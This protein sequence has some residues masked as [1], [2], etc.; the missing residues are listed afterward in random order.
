MS[1]FLGVDG[2]GSKTLAVITDEKGHVLGIGRSEGSNYQSIGIDKATQHIGNAIDCALYDANLI[3]DDITHAVYGLAGADRPKDLAIVLPACRKLPIQSW[4]VVCDTMIGLRSGSPS[5]TGIVLV[6]G[7]GT[8]AAGRNKYGDEVQTGG[9]GYLYGDWA[10]GGDLARAAFRTAIRS[11]EGRE[12]YSLLVKLVPEFLGYT[13]VEHM[14]NDYLDKEYTNVPRELAIV[15]HQAANRGDTLSC[16][17]LARMGYELGLSAKSV[18]MR[19]CDLDEPLD[20]V[21]V[22]SVIQRGRHPLLI[23][24]I[25]QVL[26]DSGFEF[27]LCIPDIPPVCGAVLLAFDDHGI[28]IQTSTYDHWAAE[29]GASNHSFLEEKNV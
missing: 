18:A 6:C 12:E 19:L 20:V 4:R 16:K 17:I 8:N 2:G 26:N 5:F 22:G 27:R 7:S 15:V 23:G 14:L 3:A 28:A 1:Y 24:G 13:D 21:L 29:F 9:F 25:E 10:G 11:F